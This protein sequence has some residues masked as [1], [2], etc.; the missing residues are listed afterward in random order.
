M[1]VINIDYIVIVWLFIDIGMMPI[2]IVMVSNMYQCAHHRFECSHQ[3]SLP[4]ERHLIGAYHHLN[5]ENSRKKRDP[6]CETCLT[7]HIHL[8]W[9]EWWVIFAFIKSGNIL[10]ITPFFG[11]GVFWGRFAV[12]LVLWCSW[13]FPR[14][15]LCAKTRC[16]TNSGGLQS[17]LK[18]RSREEEEG[19]RRLVAEFPR[20]LYLVPGTWRLDL[21]MGQNWVPEC[22]RI[23]GWLILDY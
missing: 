23:I 21:G 16:K 22:T 7:C 4:H 13:E 8:D 20:L 12:T 9:V 11:G 2:V 15:F 5:S 1:P 19:V 10:R 17:L 6:N 18:D 14:G 3:R